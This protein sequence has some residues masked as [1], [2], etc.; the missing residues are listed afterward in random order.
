MLRNM[1]P[2]KENYKLTYHANSK[3]TPNALRTKSG[4]QIPH[5]KAFEWV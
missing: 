1:Y 2:E 5:N 4:F 3:I